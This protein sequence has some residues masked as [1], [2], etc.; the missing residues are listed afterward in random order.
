MAGI[1]GERWRKAGVVANSFGVVGRVESPVGDAL[2]VVARGVDFA[3]GAHD[4]L[5]AVH[6][7]HAVVVLVADQGV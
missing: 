3:E 1:F 6:L 4:T 5:G 7:D 2:G